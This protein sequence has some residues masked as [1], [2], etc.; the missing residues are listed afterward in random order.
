MFST[1]DDSI[2]NI[3]FYINQ[4]IP[5]SNKNISVLFIETYENVCVRTFSCIMDRSMIVVG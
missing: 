3:F 4:T 2:S 5:D 1:D